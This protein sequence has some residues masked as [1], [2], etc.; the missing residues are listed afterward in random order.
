MY[1]GGVP[2]YFNRKV[3]KLDLEAEFKEDRSSQVRN[4]RRQ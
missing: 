4:E 1:L 3:R 2:I